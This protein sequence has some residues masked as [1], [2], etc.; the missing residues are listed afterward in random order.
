MKKAPDLQYESD[1]S[2]I[3]YHAQEIF[4]EE[5]DSVQSQLIIQQINQMKP[6]RI[7]S[8]QDTPV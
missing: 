5:L 2:V 1:A 3:V 7:Q 8:V 6:T 4:K